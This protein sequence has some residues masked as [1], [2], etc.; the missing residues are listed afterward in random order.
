MS[1]SD[2]AGDAPRTNRSERNILLTLV[3]VAAAEVCAFAWLFH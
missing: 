2:A 1:A 3:F